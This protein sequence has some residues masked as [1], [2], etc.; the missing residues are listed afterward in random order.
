MINNQGWQGCLDQHTGQGPRGGPCPIQRSADGAIQFSYGATVVDQSIAI[1][2]ALNGTGIQVRGY[3]YSWNIKNDNAGAAGQ[4]HEADPLEITVKLTGHDS[5]VLESRTY[6]YSYRIFGWTTYSG[7]ETYKNIYDLKQVNTLSMEIYGHDRGYWAGYHG[8]EIRDIDLRLRYSIDQCAVNPLTSPDCP[9]YAQA[10]LAQQCSLSVF[11]SPKCPGY[12]SA[13]FN[14]QCYLN[15]LYNPQCPGYAQALFDQQCN[16]D[17][18]YNPQCPGYQAAFQAKL[19]QQACQANPQS[20]PQCSGYESAAAKT[21]V[22]E[23]TTVIYQDPVAEVTEVA[24]TPDLVVNSV[25]KPDKRILP[26][27]QVSAGPDLGTGLIIPG[28]RLPLPHNKKNSQDQQ[29]NT[30]STV[31][32]NQPTT[33]ISRA[34]TTIDA[35]TQQQN[36]VI[37]Q[38]GSVPGFAAYQNAGLPDAPFYPAKDIYRGVVIRDNAQAQRALSQRSDRLHQEMINEQYR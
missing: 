10:Y 28:L 25:I 38:M 36:S 8:P 31:K 6:K 9:G 37:D 5:T 23:S 27:A 34:R 7:T 18:F 13:V 22:Y 17:V 15:A 30:V 11:F 32:N 24:V 20:N 33:R 3:A 14:Q 1:N 12:E 35:N 19:Q 4:S 2:Q 26:D 21:Q 16:I 29:E